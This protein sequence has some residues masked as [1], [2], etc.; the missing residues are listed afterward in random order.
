[1]SVVSQTILRVFHL[2]SSQPS[3]GGGIVLE[4]LADLLTQFLTAL[5]TLPVEVSRPVAPQG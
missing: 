1:M 5:D 3:Q 2:E 4:W